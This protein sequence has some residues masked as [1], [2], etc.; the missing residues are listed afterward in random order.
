ML[1]PDI[2][3]TITDDDCPPP[4]EYDIPVNDNYLYIGGFV[5]GEIIAVMVYHN[6]KDGKKCHVQVLPEYRHEYAAIFGEQSLMFK[7]TQTLYAEIPECHP[8]VLDFAFRFGFRVIET[9]EQDYCKNGNKYNTKI[10]R[11]QNG[12]FS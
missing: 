3:D 6:Y 9:K 12:F 1:H 7:G 5:N 8:N 2:F 11:L 10:L 4:E